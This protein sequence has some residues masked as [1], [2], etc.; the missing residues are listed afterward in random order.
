VLTAVI[1]RCSCARRSRHQQP[2][3]ALRPD[4]LTNRSAMAF[5]CGARTGVLT[6]RMPALRN[7]SLKLPVHLLARQDYWRPSADCQP[8]EAHPGGDVREKVV[9]AAH[10][11]RLGPPTVAVT[12]R[13]SGVSGEETRVVSPSA[14]RARRLDCREL[15]VPSSPEPRLT[16]ATCP[17]HLPIQQPASARYPSARS[18]ASRA[19]RHSSRAR[20]RLLHRPLPRSRRHLCPVLSRLRLE[21]RRAGAAHRRPRAR[22]PS[23]A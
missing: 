1:G 15:R 2:V 4:G 9:V 21:L 19:V 6:T 14:R 7:T 20:S 17:A 13:G 10:D 8:P 22:S 16:R 3:E 18:G 12:M 11:H 5:A 23:A